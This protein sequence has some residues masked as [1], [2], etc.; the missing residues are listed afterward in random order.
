MKT[1]KYQA[2]ITF[3]GTRFSIMAGEFI[4]LEPKHAAEFVSIGY[5]SAINTDPETSYNPVVEEAETAAPTI[6]KRRRK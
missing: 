2:N 3:S 6:T 5:L 4:D 1:Q